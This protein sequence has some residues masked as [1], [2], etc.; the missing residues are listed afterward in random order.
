MCCHSDSHRAEV[1]GYGDFMKTQQS[2]HST[3]LTMTLD[4]N[5]WVWDMCVM[6]SCCHWS[7]THLTLYIIEKMGTTEV[8]PVMPVASS[9]RQI[10]SSKVSSRSLG[11]V[12]CSAV[13]Q[14]NTNTVNVPSKHA[15]VTYL[16]T[17]WQYLLHKAALICM[18]W[19]TQT[20]V[21][22]VKEQLSYKWMWSDM[23]ITCFTV[24]VRWGIKSPGENVPVPSHDIR[25]WSRASWAFR[26]LMTADKCL[27]VLFYNYVHFRPD[28]HS[29]K[30]WI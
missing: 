4:P 22:Q 21:K 30:N 23:N 19:Q 26:I 12:R 18:D 16:R 6:W 8:G 14:R 20:E 29:H 1:H 10:A 7:N 15:L 3:G 27:F 5:D 2:H 25:K 17:P 13:W 11:C 9:E 24:K 28:Q